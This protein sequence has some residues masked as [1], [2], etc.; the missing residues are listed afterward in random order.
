MGDKERA[1]ANIQ[2]I[3][4]PKPT[5]ER[6]AIAMLMSIWNE[7]DISHQTMRDTFKDVDT[8]KLMKQLMDDSGLK[9]IT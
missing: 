1:L 4:A 6:D 8:D 3:L 9:K 7:G 2:K 5:P